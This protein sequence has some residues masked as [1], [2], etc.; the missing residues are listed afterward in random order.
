MWCC[1]ITKELL[2][3]RHYTYM[4]VLHFLH[5]HHV[6]QY[7]FAAKSAFEYSVVFLNKPQSVRF[8]N[9]TTMLLEQTEVVTG[10]SL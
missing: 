3:Q 6:E 7:D 8:I 10:C 1:K 9:M 5:V 2:G 4:L